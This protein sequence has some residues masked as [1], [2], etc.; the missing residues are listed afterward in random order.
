M[1]SSNKTSPSCPLFPS[2]P[3]GLKDKGSLVLCPLILKEREE[4]N[5]GERTER[6]TVF[7]IFSL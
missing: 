4:R 5:G 1:V 2:F 7:L 6:L 3:L